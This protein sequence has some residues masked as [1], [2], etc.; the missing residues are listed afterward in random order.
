MTVIF[1]P[2]VAQYQYQMNQMSTS[3]MGTG[4]S[5][6]QGMPGRPPSAPGPNAIPSMSAPTMGHQ[7]QGVSLYSTAAPSYQAAVSATSVNPYMM[8]SQAPMQVSKKL[9]P[10]IYL[11]K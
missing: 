5:A 8:Q 1:L 6:P 7:P 4:Q 9:K 3:Q 2:S 10:N 11:K